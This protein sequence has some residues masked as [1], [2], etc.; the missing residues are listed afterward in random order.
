M[1][2]Q[3]YRRLGIASRMSEVMYQTLWENNFRCLSTISRHN[4]S[5]LNLHEQEGRLKVLKELPN[6][7]LFVEISKPAE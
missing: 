4:R 7:Y 6:D 1:V 2:D 3:N 5:I